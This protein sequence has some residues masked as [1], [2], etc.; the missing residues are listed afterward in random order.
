MYWQQTLYRFNFNDHKV[1]N[2]QVHVIAAIQLDAFVENG[3]L[4]LPAKLDVGPG[5]LVTQA[6]LVSRLQQPGTQTAMDINCKADH[7]LRNLVFSPRLCGACVSLWAP[8][9]SR[10]TAAECRPGATGPIPH[11]NSAECGGAEWG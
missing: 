9:A 11:G 1:V 8:A 3:K 7:A 10:A 6:F 5:Q 2:D 4:N